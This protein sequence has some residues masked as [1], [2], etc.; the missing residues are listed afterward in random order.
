MWLHWNW[1][2]AGGSEFGLSG[3]SSGFSSFLITDK[4]FHLSCLSFLICKRGIIILPCGVIESIKWT[5]LW[6]LVQ[7]HGTYGL[8]NLFYYEVGTQ[9]IVWATT[10]P[11]I[12]TQDMKPENELPWLLNV[13]IGREGGGGWWWDSTSAELSHTHDGPVVRH[14]HSASTPRVSWGRSVTHKRDTWK[15]WP[16]NRQKSLK[17]QDQS[18][19]TQ[20]TTRE[21]QGP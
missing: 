13:G 18:S 9:G 14:H 8:N 10:N 5:C 16:Q 11:S 19:G 6:N 12:H 20:S 3:F 1:L 4:L 21:R 7:I 2:R 17:G 15:H